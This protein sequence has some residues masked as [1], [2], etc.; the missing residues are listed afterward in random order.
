M[1]AIDDYRNKIDEIDKEITRLFEERMDIV[2]KVGEYKKQN[3]LPVFNK[4]REDEVIEKNIG[5]LNNKDYAEG[6]KQFFI[7]IMNISKDL[8]DKEVKED[9]RATTIDKFKEKNAKS[10][11]KVGFYGVA[12]SFSEE[13]MIKHF[14][15][16]DDAKAYDEFE[17]VFVAVKNG[18]IDY[19]V[20]P[21][22]N[23]STGAIS[24]VYDLLYKYGFYIVG[25][26]CIKIDQN[27]IGI[28]GT[29]LDNVKEVYSHPQGFEQ[30]TDF[31]KEYSN[32]KKIPFHS[33]ADSVKLVSDLQDMSKVAIASKR[34]AD[35]YN[36]SIIKENINNRRENSTRFIVISKE[37][38]LNNSCDKVSVVFSL[39]HKAGTLYKLLRHFAENNIN[40]MK[41]ESRPMEK[42]AW[43]YFL[44][45]DFEGNLE[46][47]QVKKALNLIEQ[48]SAYFK[49]IG[50]YRKYY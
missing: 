14:G 18:E 16:K 3:N 13:A 29:K 28:K 6:L 27:L 36:L 39:E 37:L 42:G 11:V 41:I 50:G 26:E 35:I 40:M 9:I 25:E 23:S 10:D 34:A 45:V 49:L 24:Q 44:Y 43:K 2:I 5:Y 21:I 8:E 7:N 32:W 46:N 17:D 30:S 22:E 1:A 15:K 12:G 20:L 19:G 48:S 4:A 38:E 33:T 47:E 31:L